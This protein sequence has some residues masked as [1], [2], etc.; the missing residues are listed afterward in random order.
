MLYRV[1]SITV[2]NTSLVAQVALKL[3]IDNERHK[4]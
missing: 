1:K 3:Q 4:V 2:G